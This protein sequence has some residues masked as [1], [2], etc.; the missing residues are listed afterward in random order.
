LQRPLPCGRRLPAAAARSPHH[1]YFRATRT[2]NELSAQTAA[3]A[4]YRLADDLDR[5]HARGERG[6][7]SFAFEPRHHLADTAV[8]AGPEPDMTGDAAG[9]VEFVR[10]LPPALV[11]IGGSK[12]QKHFLV[13]ADPHPGDLRFVRG[14]AEHIGGRGIEPQ[15][16]VECSARQRRIGRQ[17]RPLIRMA[18]QVVECHAKGADRGVQSR[19]EERPNQQWCFVLRDLAGI[20]GFVD[21]R[22]KTSRG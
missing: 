7:H 13:L 14:G 19:R 22:A 3:V 10:A 12:Q 9:D 17:D 11:T 5:R 1:C 8:D 20:G 15:G 2:G 16:F 6:K 4:I 21:L 18:R